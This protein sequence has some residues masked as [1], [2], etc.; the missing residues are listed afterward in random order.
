MM[1]T[2][3]LPVLLTVSVVILTATGCN[4]LGGMNPFNRKEKILPGERT[5]VLPQPGADADVAGG[6]PAI[7]GTSGLSDW[8]QPGGNAANAP[9]NVSLAGGSGTQAWR[10]RVIDS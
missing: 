4:A 2:R 5:A 10:A 8:S 3:K 6:T 7:G 9:G 1:N